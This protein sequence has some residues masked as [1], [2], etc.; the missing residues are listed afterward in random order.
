[1]PVLRQNA[2]VTFD[3]TRRS[4]IRAGLILT[5]TGVVAGQQRA[6]LPPAL[7][8]VL[9]GIRSERLMAHITT[10]ASDAFEGRG[11]G[12]RG[13]TRT[14]E[15]LIDQ[16]T[17]AGLEPGNPDGTYVQQVPLVGYT[18]VPEFQIEAEG[19][20]TS[21]TF[22]DDFVHDYPAL[23]PRA[24]AEQ[25]GIVFAGYGIVAPEYG[26]ND[27][28]G[29]DVKGKLVIV[30]SGEPSSGD[31]AFFKGDARTYY[32]TRD[33]KFDLAAANGAAAIL[34]VSEPG[35][36]TT[37][38]LFQT[39]ARMEG[40]ELASTRG[41]ATILTGLITTAA[42]R[43]VASMAGRDFDRLATDAAGPRARPVV[44]NAT[45]G[46]TVTSTLRDVVSTNVVARVEGSDPGLKDEYVIYSAH[47]DHLGT[48]PAL[49]GDRIY[50]GAI[51]NAVGTAQLIEIARGFAALAHK[52]K[53]SVLFIAVT[54]EEK[55]YLGSRFYAQHPLFPLA[56]TIANINLDGGNVW[57]VT[58]DL[59]ASGYGL[60]TLDES[61]AA[62]ALVQGRTFITRSI[63]DGS[64]YFASDQIEFAKAG[65]PAVFPFS[66]SEYV[67]RPK[68]FGDAQWNAYGER[69]Y[70]QVSDEVRPDW[71]LSGAAEDARWLLIAGYN[72]ADSLTRPEWKPGSEFTRAPAIK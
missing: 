35:P 51:D 36:G 19:R 8:D 29:V 10:L 26:W 58:S 34:V 28:E 21:L 68:E 24:S 50:N 65:I 43:R 52:P 64:L 44:L 60:S 47:W 61:L 37:Y 66:G 39:F 54:A 40:F 25:A 7:A 17:R 53:R 48:D 33:F 59:I 72:V 71:D 3:G 45:A 11:P 12:T 18:S 4:L 23:R 30:L 63:D 20:M 57:G 5:M 56:Q 69:D 38:S 41:S 9:D 13:E 6:P 22:L 70:H 2:A 14:V 55:G 27:Y 31:P 15:Y 16:F 62:A 46:I 32:S 67:G 49:A 42:A 1:V